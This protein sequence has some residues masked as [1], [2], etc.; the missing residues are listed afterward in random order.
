MIRF[1]GLRLSR[2]K[3][4]SSQDPHRRLLVHLRCRQKS[5]SQ[6]WNLNQLPFQA[7]GV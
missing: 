1:Q 3:E 2:R 4:N 5:T 7:G 6:C